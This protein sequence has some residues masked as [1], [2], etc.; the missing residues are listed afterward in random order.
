MI[1]AAIAG[2][3]TA[4]LISTMPGVVVADDELCG[5]FAFAG[6]YSS[7][8]TARRE[9]RDLD[10]DYYDLD[11][12]DSPN[13]GEGFWVVAS[14]PFTTGRKARNEAKRLRVEEDVEGA[15]AKQ[16]CFYIE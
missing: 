4:A 3:V 10:L 9:A 5:W 2:A 13:A 7:K 15:Y 6:A 14:G 12:S 16:I 8:S 11:E 1:R